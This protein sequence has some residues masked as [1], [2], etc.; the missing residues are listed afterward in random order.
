MSRARLTAGV[1]RGSLAV[2]AFIAY[3]PALLTK[4]GR[5]PT[6]TKLYLYLDPGRLITDA[7]FTWDTRQF[8]GWVPHQTIAYLW[9]QGP[10]Y[11]VCEQLGLSDWVAHRLWIG[12]LMFLG[13][14]GVMWMARLL[15]L[16]RGGALAA[17]AVYMLSPYLLPYISRTSAMLM[18][19]AALGWIV[20]LTIRSATSE[21]RWRHPALLALVLLSCS[22]VNATAVL[23]I[24]PAPV[25][26][27]LHA[28]FQR[29]VTWQRALASAA[30][31]GVLSIGVSLWWILMLR[32]QGAHGAD[33]LAYSESLQATSLTSVS[34]E[35]L[36]GLGYWLFYVRDPYAFTTTASQ[37]YMESGRVI[38]ISFLVVVLCAAG[39]A[40][41]RWSQRRYAALL[42]FV[43]IVLAVGVH[44]IDNASP[45]MSPLAENSRSALA[46]AIRSSTRALPMSILGFA[47]G[48]GA[49]VTALSATRFR[50]RA[51]T[52][53]FVVLLAVVNLPALFDGGLVDPALERDQDPPAAWQQAADD[54]SS[55]SSE[56]RVLQL[57]GSEFGA[58]RWGYTVDPPLPGMTT[59]PL[60]TR[61]LLPLGSAG[62][63]DLLYALDDRVQSRTLDPDAVA[64]VA[65]FLGVDTIWLAN[66][67]A[68]DRF[69]TPRP[70]AVAD[71][72][73]RV[74]GLGTPTDYGDPAVNVP[75]IPMVD[76]HALSSS[77]RAL[78]TVALY[79]VT[80]PVPIV[81]AADRVVVLA[82]SGDGVI[83]AAAAGL[84]HGDEALVYA[85][86]D[87]DEPAIVIV[88]DSNRDRAHHWRSSQDVSGFTEAGGDGSDVLR[89]DEGDQRLPVFGPVA[90]ANDQTIAVLD[91]PLT[92][93]A[94][95]YGEPFAYRPEQRPAMAVDGDPNTA[96]VV[97]DRA[98]PIGHFIT[99]SST[100]GRLTLLQAAGRRTIT[101]VRITTGDGAA[102]DV[103]L[104][105]SSRIAPGQKVDLPDT[106]SV[107]I[108]ITGVADVPTDPDT[109]PSAV[110]FAELGLGTHTEVVRVPQ[111][112]AADQPLAVVLSRLR[113]DP[114]N[115]WRSDPEPSMVRQFDTSSTRSMELTVTL[116][117]HDRATDDLLNQLEGVEG[118]VADQRLTGDP[119]ARGIYAADGDTATAWTSPFGRAVGSTVH[120][121]LDAPVTQLTLQQ[122]TDEVHS[123][124]TRLWLTAGA[125]AV[126]VDVSAPDA[127]GRSIVTLPE[128]MAGPQLTVTVTAIEPRTT[129]DR[130]FAE[131]TVL[132]VAIRELSGDGI[133]TTRQLPTDQPA[134]RDDL[135]SI[136]G[137]PV[138]VQFDAAALGRGDTISVQPCDGAVVELAAG[139]HRV[140]ST[141]GA[142]TGVDVNRVVLSDL[143]TT[144]PATPPTVEV[145]R[146]RTSRTATVAPCPSGCW[147][148][149]GEGW[150]TGWTA[151]TAGNDLGAP[152]QIAGGFNGWWIAPTESP[153][154]VDIEWQA[155]TPVTLALVVSGLATIVCVVL[156]FRRRR[157]TADDVRRSSAPPRFTFL[158]RASLRDS[159]VS[160]V[161]LVALTALVAAPST[162]LIAA[163]P[164]AL[165]VVFRRPRIAAI[166]GVGLL[167]LLA[168]R[169]VQRQLTGRYLANA[170]WPSAWEKLHRPGVLV[171]VLL[172]V[173]ALADRDADDPGTEPPVDEPAG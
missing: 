25:L 142:A 99:A 83:D 17:A 109:G 43:G 53:A 67:L 44:P 2:L 77:D 122:P 157:G 126:E 163:V 143:A 47:L 98:D 13:A 134:C 69:R 153:T 4:P 173:S 22:A 73:E 87:T 101:S 128:P 15:G 32:A 133:V 86:D 158:P 155:Q 161:A 102:I 123:R 5:M 88:T 121:P 24:A 152:T 37:V 76:E 116:H 85:A 112:D 110:G 21:R 46:L 120:F 106:S 148:I 168:A 11:W 117:R 159:I 147:L 139:T 156:A 16:G 108:T 137:Q 162:A 111:Y 78:P 74:P 39:L 30:R 57:P 54:L 127:D 82:G 63:M 90:D 9:P 131:V 75:D 28:V 70:T 56:Y 49:L 171:V 164:A 18:P 136:D 14:W 125:E 138:S 119:S 91:P 61:D 38:A 52:P 65:R 34:T 124:I 97:A 104:D 50:L 107:T 150:N 27:L 151:S 130:R 95:G 160:A 132:P 169:V 149:M 129:I 66:D 115:R 145:T 8:A 81:R 29:S 80:D 55:T 167:G 36:R 62:A 71:E 72:F 166:A 165:V 140:T 59:K 84:L 48:V 58:F 40:F 12:T 100:E 135:L 31:I 118:A 1:S 103:A 10:W 114:L 96:W 68:F 45:L 64:S 93:Q 144:S 154:V 19:W 23:M 20:G 141:G 172:L 170:A 42:V 94:S 146:T 51:L 105:D 7:P 60:A 113:A 33:V 41:T 92:V 3:L 6:D 35:T 26:W 89:I 79:P